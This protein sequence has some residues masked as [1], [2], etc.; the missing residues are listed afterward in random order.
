[1]T[2]EEM[3]KIKSEMDKTRDS[4]T[5]FAI[6]NDD[7]LAVVGDAND[8]KTV[9]TD[10][11]ITFRF[12]NGK[13][14]VMERD[15]EY[16]NIFITPRQETKVVRL[17]A[18]LLPYYKKITEDGKLEDYSDDEVFQISIE[19]DEQ[20]YDLMYELVANVLDVAPEL[21]DYMVPSSVFNAV[22]KIIRY[23]PQY[24]S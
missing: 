20:I 11:T 21:K 8:T 14:G 13:G 4:D 1:M 23:Y 7:T 9:I 15:V 2:Q 12:P 16:K 18:E 17:F 24:I 5:P 6:V 19:M 10:Y 22:T 3:L